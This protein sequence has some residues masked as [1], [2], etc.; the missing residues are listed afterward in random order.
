MADLLKIGF[1][2]RPVNERIAELT[3]ATGVPAPFVL[4]AYFLSSDPPSDEKQIHLKLSKERNQERNFLKYRLWK[5]WPLHNQCVEDHQSISTAILLMP[6][7]QLVKKRT[8][9]FGRALSEKSCVK[10]RKRRKNNTPKHHSYLPPGQV[11][12]V[13]DGV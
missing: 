13:G 11:S 1:S 3:S 7:A 6:L 4:Q 8:I 5:R 2:V 12:Q 9:N 10:Q